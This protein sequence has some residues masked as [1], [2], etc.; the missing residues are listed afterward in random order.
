[1]KKFLVL[2]NVSFL[3]K[4]LEFFIRFLNFFEFSPKFWPEILD[5]LEAYVV[6]GLAPKLAN[7]SK[8]YTQ[9]NEK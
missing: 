5:Y 7:F 4:I 2:L 9:S 6:S 3:T 1:M 8:L